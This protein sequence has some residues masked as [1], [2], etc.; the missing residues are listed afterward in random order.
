MKKVVVAVT[1]KTN[2]FNKNFTMSLLSTVKECFDNDIELFFDFSGE[3][4]TEYMSKNLVCNRV[5]N[6]EKIDGVVF[7]DPNLQWEPKTL[8][9]II[10]HEEDIVS[11]V[12]PLP[13]PNQEK[14]VVSLKEGYDVNA[15]YI[16][17]N[18]LQP[19]AC[20]VSK[21]ALVKISEICKFYGDKEF[22]F[23]F[24]PDFVDGV[25][26]TSD[27][28]FFG[29]ASKLDIKLNL[30]PHSSF[31]NTGEVHYSGD[32]LKTI[33]NNWVEDSFTEENIIK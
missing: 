31:I 20:Y 21:E 17:S 32:F 16:D 3:E 13:D 14:Y 19:G 11:G 1:E 9:D 15:K 24:M 12:Y 25:Y 8:I 29:L 2:K 4:I 28:A 5:L 6:S 27:D 10:N 33:S 26:I 7:L 30:N 23:F 22:F 18:R